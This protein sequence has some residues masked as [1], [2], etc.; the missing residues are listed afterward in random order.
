MAYSVQKN[1]RLMEETHAKIEALSAAM[2][3]TFSDALRQLLQVAFESDQL[4]KR[5]NEFEKVQTA[6]MKAFEDTVLNNKPLNFK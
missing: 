3:C 6:N 4:K 2:N 5:I 1:L